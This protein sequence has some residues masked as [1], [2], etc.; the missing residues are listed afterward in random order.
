MQERL[1]NSCH[2]ISSLVSE[3]T[4]KHGDTL[5]KIGHELAETFNRGGQLILAGDGALQ[6]IA[7]QTATAFSHRLGF[8]RPPLPALALGGDPIFTAAL[9]A[10]HKPQEILAREYR[11]HSEREHIILIFCSKKQSP[12][13][14]HLTEQIEDNSALILIG[15]TDR[16]G[17]AQEAQQVLN[18]NFPEESPARLAEI[19]LICGHLLCELVEGELFGV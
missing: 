7:Q 19:G 2:Q 11:T 4:D 6:A 8:E 9:L 14:R 15:P 12:Q 10:D 17:L 18:L 13:I 1:S 3:L 5:I 16:E